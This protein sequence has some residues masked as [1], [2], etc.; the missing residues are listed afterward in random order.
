MQQSEQHQKLR[1]H[2]ILE[3]RSSNRSGSEVAEPCKFKKKDVRS[4]RQ[5]YTQNASK[6]QS[7]V[8][9]SISIVCNHP[10][11]STGILAVDSSYSC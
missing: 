7:R 2:S 1:F 9:V 3:K 5:N 8:L 10:L 6:N 4:L 11:H